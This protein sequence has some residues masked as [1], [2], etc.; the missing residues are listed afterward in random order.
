MHV[1]CGGYVSCLPCHLDDFCGEYGRKVS[2]LL[3]T[4]HETFGRGTVEMG[5]GVMPGRQA[6]LLSS[7]IW[8]LCLVTSPVQGCLEEGYCSW[9]KLQVR[10]TNPPT[11]DA[12]PTYSFSYIQETGR[13]IDRGS[14]EGKDHSTI[15]SCAL[16][17]D[18]LPDSEKEQ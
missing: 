11:G 1:F 17:R 16:D 5:Q 14:V 9:G 8:Y 2:L 7:P 13:R 15:H 18:R 6:G 3:L 10:P 4:Y 12:P